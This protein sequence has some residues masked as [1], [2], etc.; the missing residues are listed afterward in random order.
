[1][2]DQLQRIALIRSV[3]DKYHE[4]EKSLR[5]TAVAMGLSVSATRKMLV[6]AREY[7]SPRK[8]EIDL[9]CKQ[10]LSVQ[11]IADHLGIGVAA[12]NS[13]LPYERGTY[14]IPA[15]TKNAERV[16]A[17]RARKAAET[18]QATEKKLT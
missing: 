12:V 18:S 15:Q 7:D 5:R 17:C 9:L 4:E 3:V 16:R 10:G 11:Q 1:M 2:S 8:R 14:I 13:Y 6:T